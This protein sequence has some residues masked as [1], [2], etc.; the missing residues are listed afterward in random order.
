MVRKLCG[1][2]G[3]RTYVDYKTRHCEQHTGQVDKDYNRF[4]RD[5]RS[6]AFYNSPAWR[7][8][9]KS[10]LAENPLCVKC[11]DEGVVELAVIVDHIVELK[12]DWERR[13]DKSNLEG[14]CR[15]C[16]NKKTAEEKLKRK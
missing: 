10:V 13:L 3:C 11:M 16:H 7:N 15:G 4:V 6:A 8:L 1:Y 2:P 9:R 14:L 5:E 12:D